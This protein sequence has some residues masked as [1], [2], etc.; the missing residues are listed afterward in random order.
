MP[1]AITPSPA[2][3]AFTD[4][5]SVN[6][7]SKTKDTASVEVS[8][9]S[10]QV[11]HY[12]VID[13]CCVWHWT[14][15]LSPAEGWIVIDS[16]V[17]TAAGG[18]LFLHDRATL[19][20]VRDVAQSM[21]AKLAVSSQPQIV[22]AKGG[23]RFSPRDSRA[24]AVLERFIRD[25]APVLSQFWGTGGDINTNH[26]VID[27]HAR[28][29]CAPGTSTAL[30]A[31]RL[32]LGCVGS[33][34]SDIPLLLQERLAEADWPLEEYT[35]GHVMAITLRELLLHTNPKL[36]GR[37]R[38]VIQGFGCV[39][40][41]FACAAQRLGLGRVVAISSQYGYYVDDDGIDCAAIE[42]ARRLAIKA[43]GPQEF[44]PRS[45]E[46]GLASH[47]LKSSRYTTR[48]AGS[49]DVDH[50]S[51]FLTA[52]R[53]DVFVPCA[54]RYVLTPDVVKTLVRGTFAGTAPG[55]RFILAGANNIFSSD[56]SNEIMLNELD[57]GSI[58]MLPEW[59]SN[60]GTANLFMRACSGLALKGYGKYNLEA[61][62]NDTRAFIKAAM[63]KTGFK[64]GSK[65]MWEACRDLAAARREAGAVNL[66]GVH[67]LS[68]MTLHTTK[69]ERAV[70]TL[71][72][73]FNAKSNK[74]GSLFLLPSSDDPTVSIVR[75]PAGTS[76]AYLGLRS[77]FAVYN[78]GR[79]REV[80]KAEK[81]SFKECTLQD[82]T[83]ELVLDR[84]EA[85]YPMSLCQ[86]STQELDRAAFTSAPNVL[87]SVAEGARHVDHFATIMPDT[88]KI[89]T[90]HERMLGFTHVRTF[91]V[92]AGSAADGSDDGL[93]H[94]MAFPNDD[95][96]VNI[97]TEGLNDQSVFSK[98]LK[99]N[100]GSYIHHVALK[101]D[102]V[103]A[104][105]AEVREQGWGTTADKLS[106]DLATGLR[107]FFVKED[108]AGCI[109]E[110]I[111]HGKVPTGAENEKTTA[112]AD[113]DADAEAAPESDQGVGGYSGRGEFR[114]GNIV[115]LAQSLKDMTKDV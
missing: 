112:L 86:V 4:L 28:K 83:V 33:T 82:G 42:S 27:K 18:G 31:L 49:S 92:N 26:D 41:T 24:A 71:T 93:M 62:A 15:K 111:G 75:A 99:L 25:N 102:D 105:F 81:L 23:I 94:V 108:E 78:L 13:G 101:V 22:G 114:T 19:G 60:S 52:S 87:R 89:K 69:Y 107:Q 97:L 103:D 95:E 96:R 2:P 16:P 6:V 100:C 113:G 46:A 66:L 59:V 5:P 50:L 106:L 29:Y 8:G 3:A 21:S 36:I 7:H 1:S 70:E 64:T 65:A 39:G 109:L 88:S 85:G 77:R 38:L 74:D 40:T 72:R 63:S 34:P 45:L 12:R 53:A 79:A 10:R 43:Q 17:P 14:D 58:S 57:A 54:Q 55:S 11:P 48:K 76:Q 32:A 35:V 84:E 30:D 110:L 90:F 20:E 47:E 91:T 115:E 68:H 104:V 80:L 37:A 51:A 61:S 56:Y 44:D 73:V 98:L 67:R 9:R